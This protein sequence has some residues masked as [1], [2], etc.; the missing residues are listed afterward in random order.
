VLDSEFPAVVYPWLNQERLARVKLLLIPSRNGYANET[1]IKRILLENNVRIFNISYVQFL[2]YRYN[3]RNLAEFCRKNNI[4]LVIDAMQAAGTCPIDVR[5]MGIDYLCTGNQKWL[6]SP[7]GAG[8]AYVSKNYR[9]FLNPTY[10]ST[11]NINYNF[12]NFLDYKLNFKPGG[13]AYENSTLNL[14]GILGMKEVIEYFLHLGVESIFNHIL[15]LQDHF[16]R[17]L[18]MKKYTIYSDLSPDHRSGILLFSHTDAARNKEIHK[19]LESKRI[20]IALREGY[21][22]LSPHIYNN[23]KDVETLANELNSL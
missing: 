1:V 23:Y 7:A 9:Q 16:I 5:A 4:L 2:G 17:L 3:I 11:L 19:I 8:F 13:Q 18:D 10:V 15:K 12:E 20:F 22:R 14:L 6:M 21:L